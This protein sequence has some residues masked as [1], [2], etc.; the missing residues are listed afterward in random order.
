[1]DLFQV[2]VEIQDDSHAKPLIVHSGS[3]TFGTFESSYS[4]EN[5]SF[6]YESRAPILKNVSFNVPGGK[7][8]AIVGPSGSGKSTLLRLVFLNFFLPKSYFVSMTFK[9]DVF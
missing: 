6:Y 9:K 7:T 8:L 1:M 2:P 4:L 5:V 3:V